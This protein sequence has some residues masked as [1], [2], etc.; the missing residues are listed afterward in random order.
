MKNIELSYAPIRSRFLAFLIDTFIIYIIR[1]VYLSLSNALYF[2]DLLKNFITTYYEK[3]G[4]IKSIN[5]FN[6]QYI[7]ESNFFKILII[8]IVSIFF[9]STIYNIICLSTK[10]SSTIGQKIL[11]I[12]IVSSNGSKI[13]VLQ[14]IGRSFLIILPSISLF[15]FSLIVIF[16]EAL[17]KTIIDTNLFLLYSL[18][19]LSWYDMIFFTKD[20]ILFHDFATKTRVVV[21]NP[22]TY[23]DS[24]YM[25][26][27]DFIF[28]SIK[29]LLIDMKNVLIKHY[30]EIKNIFKTNNK[31]NNI[32]KKQDD[33]VDNN[34]NSEKLNTE[35]V[36]NK[37][38]KDV[39]EKEE[40]V[41]KKT[42]KKTTKKA[43]KKTTK[44][45]K[46]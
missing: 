23:Y 22:D 34:F 45:S 10:W 46:K 20:K 41:S 11:G 14:N 26:V 42:T 25:A 33:N 40:K 16:N 19:L 30:Y 12:H 27:V 17:L 44:K 8:Y 36:S 24:R 28:P 5:E 43:N 1:F 39:K 13:N 9:I 6:T 38:K 4:E 18:L 21:N 31:D 15:I 3:Y 2:N 35:K 29:D 7:F 37:N 32:D